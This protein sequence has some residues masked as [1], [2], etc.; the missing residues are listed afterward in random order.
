MDENPL[1]QALDIE[2]LECLAGH[3]GERYFL[4]VGAETGTVARALYRAGLAGDLVDPLPRHA[5]TLQALAAMHGG[6]FYP[7]AL[8]ETEG[9]RPFHIAEDAEG[10]EL[11]YFHSLQVIEPQ[12]QFRHGRTIDV[13]CRRID[14]MVAEGLLPERIGILKTDTEGNDFFVLQGLG[15]VRPE[16]VVCE[17]FQEQMYSGWPHGRAEVMIRQ[18]QE[19]GYRHYYAVKRF[20]RWSSVLAG[21]AAFKPQDW[22]NLFFL[23]ETLFERSLADVLALM[24]QHELRQLAELEALHA[25]WQAK[26][27]VIQQLVQSQQQEASR[28][29]AEQPP[30][31]KTFWERLW[32][33]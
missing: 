32:G 10:N 29:T 15:A 33:R 27:Q 14:Q 18:M 8:A 25:D 6:R 31:N 13:Q 12:E 7:L 2:L 21:P 9:V 30:A 17:F 11:D 23:N 24:R 19:L 22:G 28:V 16:L 20:S 26:E 3:V 5:E 1:N 4:D